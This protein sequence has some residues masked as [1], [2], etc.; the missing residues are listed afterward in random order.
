[1]QNPASARKPSEDE[2]C[3]C[4]ILRPQ[5]FPW[6]W[7]T[8]AGAFKTEWK[9]TDPSKPRAYCMYHLSKRGKR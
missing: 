4:L 9:Y 5:G 8:Q 3:Y 7:A 2:S 1:M 6:F